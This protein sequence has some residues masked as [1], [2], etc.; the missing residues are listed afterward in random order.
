MI[1][2]GPFQRGMFNP[3]TPPQLPCTPFLGTGGCS[4]ALPHPKP[5]QTPG[6]WQP[7]SPHIGDYPPCTSPSTSTFPQPLGK[8]PCAHKCPQGDALR[9]PQQ[10][11]TSTPP[12]P[13]HS[14]PPSTAVE[15]AAAALPY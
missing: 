1:L 5:T 3:V 11:P 6:L 9:D 15:A 14:D 2:R 10:C 8:A 13:G 12:V 4:S 7:Q